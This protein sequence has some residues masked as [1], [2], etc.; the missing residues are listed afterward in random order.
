MRLPIPGGGHITIDDESTVAKNIKKG[1]RF[2]YEN[3][4]LVV[5]E[6]QTLEQQIKDCRSIEELKLILLQL[7]AKLDIKD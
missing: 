7:V 5:G 1:H 2:R 3:D 4:T 6:Q